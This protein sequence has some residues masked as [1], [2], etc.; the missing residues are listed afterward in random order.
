M[1]I[2]NIQIDNMTVLAPLAG[3]TN[4]PFR[5]IVR[6]A[7]CGLVCSEMISANG[8]IY[9]SGKTRNMLTSGADEQPISFQL[10]GA[11]PAIM[12]DAAVMAADAGA[13]IIDINCGCSVKKILKGGAGSALMKD[14]ERAREIF[15]RVRQAI[16]IPLT[17]KIRSGW[18][19]SGKGA[20][21]ISRIAEDCGVDAITLHPR[22]AT[23]GFT[24]TSD[25]SLI[26]RLKD[27][28]SVPVIGN[29]DIVRPEDAIRMLTRTGC[30]G[31]M[32]GRA[33]MGN[34]WIFSQIQDLRTHGRYAAVT[35]DQRF[36]AMKA[37][38]AASVA[39][40]GELT[41]CRMMRSRLTWLVKGLPGA[42]RF[43]ESI[44][45]IRT[46]EEAGGL[47]DSY[48]E[49]FIRDGQD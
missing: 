17:I 13:D 8:L 38:A 5:R 19:P 34:P 49:S 32:V 48:F 30:D 43:R 16:R 42:S 23:Q 2:G 4:L 9:G 6:E 22:T 47:M 46:L 35:L 28:V 41:A 11:D 12:A 31:V 39:Y 10:F 29:G 15:T 33:A 36:S 37:F 1:K 24:G 14:P 26:A 18:E 45:K 20:L 40:F 25:W 3:I 7:G 27:Q 44:T 21:D